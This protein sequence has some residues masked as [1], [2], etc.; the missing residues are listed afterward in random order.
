[1]SESWQEIERLFHASIGLP[2]PERAGFLAQACPD[3]ELRREVETLLAHAENEDG[4][5]ARCVGDVAALAVNSE[6]L[7]G[8]FIGPY[9]IVATLGCGGMGTVMLGIRDDGNFQKTVAIKVIRK[10]MDSAEVLNRFRRERQ[11]LAHLGAYGSI[12]E[13][14]T[15]LRYHGRTCPGRNA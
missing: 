11:I 2:E 15:F 6:S 9:R 12:V 10:G 13:L 3:P 7:D 14:P 4:D 1:M 8:Q 5:L